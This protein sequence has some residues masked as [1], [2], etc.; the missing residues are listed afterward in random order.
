MKPVDHGVYAAGSEE[1][2][3]VQQVS[4]ATLSSNTDYVRPAHAHDLH[5]RP[6]STFVH[7]VHTE[8][9]IQP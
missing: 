3:T 1:G 5:Q 4:T 8:G 2:S 7:L 6:T 9:I